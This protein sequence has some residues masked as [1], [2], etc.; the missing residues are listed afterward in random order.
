MVG[1]LDGEKSGRRLSGSLA[2]LLS[3]AGKREF[4][5]ARRSIGGE[6]HPLFAALASAGIYPPVE[7][8]KGHSGGA[9]QPDETTSLPVGC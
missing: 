2:L 5:R 6:A 9:R 7:G 1:R 8:L 3:G 4:R